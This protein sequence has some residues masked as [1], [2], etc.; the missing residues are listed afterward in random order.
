MR[1]G[2]NL[3]KRIVGV[4]LF[5]PQSV[6]FNPLN[7]MSP[8]QFFLKRSAIA[9]TLLVLGFSAFGPTAARAELL[10]GLTT[11]SGSNSLF[12][13]DSAT[14]G[15]VSAPVPIT[16]V[17]AET[18][19]DIDIRPADLLLYG[20]GSLGNLYSINRTTGAA[21]LSAS[22]TGV[23]LDSLATRFGID[24]NP[25]VDRLRIV[26]NTGQDLRLT[27]GTGLTT[28]DTNLNGDATGAVSVA[29]TNNDTDPAT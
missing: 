26:S 24:F 23:T 27:P 12:T 2:V 5:T 8:C 10:I 19:L 25:T 21:T 9:L 11:L 17:G 6:T 28:I 3:V 22:L 1:F 13:F 29:Y 14:P 15:T 16:G 18:I 20:L 4:R 7:L